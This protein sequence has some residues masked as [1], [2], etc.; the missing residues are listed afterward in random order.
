M[1]SVR[2]TDTRHQYFQYLAEKQYKSGVATPSNPVP[3]SR[4]A[5]GIVNEKEGVATAVD[6]TPAA[7]ASD[8][9]TIYAKYY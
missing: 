4:P 9:L 6:S 3:N 2:P 8:R 7:C 5:F 1:P